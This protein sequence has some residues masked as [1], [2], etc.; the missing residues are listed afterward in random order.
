M[1]VMRSGER[2]HEIE[3][4]RLLQEL[5]RAVRDRR[6]ERG[7]TLKALS[8]AADVSVRFIAELEA[9]RGN[10]SVARLHDV[11]VALGTSA[12]ALL[13]IEG[14]PAP[15]VIALLGLR[16]AGKSTIGKRLAKRLGRP[17][18]E[19]DAKVEEAAGLGLGA[20][21]ELH[22]EAHYRKLEREVLR[23]LLAKDEQI[24]LATGGS[25]VTDEET[26]ALLRARATTVWLQASP[27]SHWDRVVAQ[28]DRRPMHDRKDAKNELAALLRARA[29]RYARAE[30]A[31]D[32]DALGLDGAV[33]ELARLAAR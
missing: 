2:R 17:F 5:G 3:R 10:I 16:G 27:T 8:E 1:L 26:Y 25:I 30:L 20:L 4:S 11:A 7:L 29:E 18:V 22:G 32:T 23:A 21:F 12:S 6:L 33:K 13:A 15:R 14:R 19:L 31:I 28:G 9:G 24:V